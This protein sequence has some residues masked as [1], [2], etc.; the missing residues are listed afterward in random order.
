ME[1]NDELRAYYLFGLR[2][3]GDFGATLAIPAVAAAWI[4]TNIDDSWGTKPRALLACLAL[5]FLISAAILKKKAAA[6]GAD[7]QHLVNR[8]DHP[9]DRR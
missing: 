7:Y 8:Y 1:K 2:I 3:V 6:Y 4:G 9:A 5:A